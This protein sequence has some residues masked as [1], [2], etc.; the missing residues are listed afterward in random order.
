[1][2][3]PKSVS[4]SNLGSNWQP[5]HC[6]LSI[7][8]IV[9]TQA[10]PYRRGR[11]SL[12]IQPMMEG[13]CSGSTSSHFGQTQHASTTFAVVGFTVNFSAFQRRGEFMTWG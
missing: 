8:P 6:V 10:A 3:A 1:M 11:S 12:S 7:A 13:T 4:G 2:R 9:V 5:V